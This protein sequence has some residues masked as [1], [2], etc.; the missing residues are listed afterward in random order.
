MKRHSSTFLRIAALLELLGPVWADVLGNG[1]YGK[2]ALAVL[3]RCADPRAKKRLGRRRLTALLVRYSRGPSGSARPTSCSPPLTKP[4][5][6][7]T[8]GG[9]TL[10]RLPQGRVWLPW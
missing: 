8:T 3:E 1:D 7:G 6:C 5:P 10:R 2:I 9:W 4:W